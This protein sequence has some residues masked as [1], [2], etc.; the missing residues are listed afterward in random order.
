MDRSSI[1]N[2]LE[3]IRS[4]VLSEETDESKDEIYYIYSYELSRLPPSKKVQFSFALFGRKGT[5]GLINKI[6]GQ[7]LGS[8]CIFVPEKSKNKIEE[9]F[10]FWGAEYRKIRVKLLDRLK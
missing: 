1:K 10:K 9:F 6:N 8:G 4:K 5:D 7:K 2:E 3:L